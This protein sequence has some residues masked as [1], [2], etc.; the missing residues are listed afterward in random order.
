MGGRFKSNSTSQNDKP[1]SLA[2]VE[3][4]IRA[5][6]AAVAAAAAK[7]NE[8]NMV[9]KVNSAPGID[10]EKDLGEQQDQN[11]V[12]EMSMN[13]EG[14]NENGFCSDSSGSPQEDV[15]LE[16]V[17]AEEGGTVKETDKVDGGGK[18][19]DEDE[20]RAPAKSH[21]VTSTPA[22]VLIPNFNT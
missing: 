22:T 21:S 9:E 1:P 4:F 19:R 12:T 8:S 7:M 14:G 3:R 6:A 18:D 15:S 2:G 20:G 13:E 16:R 11:Q 5:K 17:E 10:L